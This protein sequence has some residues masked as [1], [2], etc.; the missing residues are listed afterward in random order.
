MRPFS[1]WKQI[2]VA[3]RD[4]NLGSDENGG[5]Y[6]S[7]ISRIDPYTSFRVFTP[8]TKSQSFKFHL[9]NE[10]NILHVASA[11]GSQDWLIDLLKRSASVDDRD[12]MGRTALHCAIWKGKKISAVQLLDTGASILA[13]DKELQNC[14][15]LQ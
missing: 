7:Q 10:T 6:K 12:G 15:H 9:N 1:A 5:L 14:L 4:G 2:F 8:Q 3:L 13:I 11:L